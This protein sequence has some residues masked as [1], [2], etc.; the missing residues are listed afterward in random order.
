MK[1]TTLDRTRGMQKLGSRV[2]PLGVDQNPPES[3]RIRGRKRMT[4][5]NRLFQRNPLCVHCKALGIVKQATEWDHIVSLVD[6]GLE[7][8]SN[9]QGLCRDCHVAKTQAENDM[10]R[11]GVAS[12]SVRSTL[13]TATPV[14]RRF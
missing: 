14:T 12:T 13:D 7:H 9:L 2:K 5:N 4:R 6:G 3:T 11:R 8:E 10:R 1:L